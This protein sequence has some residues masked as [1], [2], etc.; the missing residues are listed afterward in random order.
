MREHK[1]RDFGAQRAQIKHKLLTSRSNPI[2]T[3]GKVHV[4]APAPKTDFENEK[5]IIILYLF[6]TILYTKSQILYTIPSCAIGYSNLGAGD[7]QSP[8]PKC[9]FKIKNWIVILYSFCTIL[10]I[11][12]QIL[13]TLP[14]CDIRNSNLGAGE[15]RS[16]KMQFQDKKLNHNFLLILYNFVHQVPNF[17][18][19][20]ILCY[21][22]FKFGGWWDLVH[23][24][25]QFEYKIIIQFFIL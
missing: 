22:Q 16:P 9:S 3:F 12:S 14:S 15:M 13:Y 5:Y 20:F 25:V 7:M 1:F 23:K 6:C 10:Y 21:R 18:H 11:K 8:P 4:T 17:V 24:I 19:P 2:S